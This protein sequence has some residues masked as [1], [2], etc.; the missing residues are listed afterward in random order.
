ML[1]F[2]LWRSP[3]AFLPAPGRLQAVGFVSGRAVAQVYHGV[4]IET[5]FYKHYRKI[6]L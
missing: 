3:A 1:N 6:V 4:P 5:D 2:Y